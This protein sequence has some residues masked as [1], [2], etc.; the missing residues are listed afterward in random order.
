MS[1]EFTTLCYIR[2]VSGLFALF[3]IGVLWRHRQSKGV[4][5]LMLFELSAAI[6]AISDGF[7]SA[8]LTIEI[9]IH[10]S[11]FAYLG[12]STCSVMFLMFALSYTHQIRKT[13]SGTLL[14]LM[15]IPVITMIIALTNSYHKL[16]W[17]RTEFYEGS[18]SLIYYYGPY[19]WIQA[20]YQYGL[21][22]LGIIILMLGALKVYSQY[23]TQFWIIIVGAIFP[24]FSSVVYVFKL[25][26][27]KGF[28]PTPVSFIASGFI[29]ALGIFWF[30]MFNIMPI[31]RKQAVDNLRDGML[32][33]DASGMIVDAND[34]FYHMTGY[35]AGQIIGK[36]A[37]SFFSGIDIDTAKFSDE[38]DYAIETQIPLD[39]GPE[40]IEVKYH[41]ITDSNQKLLGGIYMLTNITTRKMILDAIADSNKRRK[42]ELIE[43]EKLILDLDAYAR[44]VAHDLKNPL[45]TMVGLADLIRERLV[46]NDIKDMEELIG[47]VGEQSRKMIR[48]IDGLLMLSR[49]RKEDIVKTPIRI[50]EILDEVFKRL[51][52]EITRYN[53]VIEKP[54]SWPLVMGH[55][56]WIE[57]VWVNLLSNALKYGGNPPVI[58]IGCDKTESGAYRF[59][60]Q[61]NGNGLP[62]SSL[63]K[64]FRDFERLGVKDS[65]GYGLGLPIVKRIFEKL[66]GE[67]V[68]ASSNKPGE[69]CIFSFTLDEAL[70]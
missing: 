64:I 44:S 23:R 43:K 11:Q 52:G 28:D 8:A 7:E 69:G 37:D 59:W 15:V 21:L 47:I 26:P 40:D 36:Q 57:E 46:A 62:G 67:I 39:S 70:E 42:F 38:N 1:Y 48:I 6:W 2:F 34:A 51:E 30:R 20:F 32:V 22:I 50:G 56:M 14:A 17:A 49:I 27:L 33:A 29:V 54:D 66:G 4:I 35:K 16:L 45:C 5:Y 19:F 61:D 12:I 55:P 60:I 10:W 24:F 58:K 25:L 13:G 31:A 68:A 63:K 18:K 65:D 53:A 41:S 3:L 9:K